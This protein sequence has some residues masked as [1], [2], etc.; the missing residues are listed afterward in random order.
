MTRTPPPRCAVKPDAPSH[1]HI[2][3]TVDQA[4]VRY[5]KKHYISLFKRE[6]LNISDHI[7]LHLGTISK[8]SLKPMCTCV[9]LYARPRLGKTKTFTSLFNCENVS[10][11]EQFQLHLA[12]IERIQLKPM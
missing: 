10:I 3:W 6:K 7:K 5:Y 11:S 2:P 1:G 12:T 8:I 4:T 9:S